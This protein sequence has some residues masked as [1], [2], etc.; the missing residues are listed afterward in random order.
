MYLIYGAVELQ[1][2][3][4]GPEFVNSVLSHP[5][6]MLGI[7]DL[8]STAYRPVANSAIERAHRTIEA[9]FVKTIRDNQK[10]WH[11]QAKFVC[12]AYNT[13]RHT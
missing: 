2:H 12:F 3:D 10:D 11:E 7:Q 5:L 9:V 6:K 8:R 13:A 1:V 4:T